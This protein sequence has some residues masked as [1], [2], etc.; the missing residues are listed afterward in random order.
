MEPVRILVL[1][2]DPRPPACPCCADLPALLRSLYPHPADIAES[3]ALPDGACDLVLVR[4]CAEDPAPITSLRERFPDLAILAL[5]CQSTH[6]AGLAAADD[7]LCCP[8][9]PFELQQ[10]LHRLCPPGWGRAGIEQQALRLRN[11]YRLEGLVGHS[12]PLLLAL[13]RLGPV[14]RSGATVLITGETGTGKELFARGVHYLS[15]RSGMPFLPVNCAA[16][17]DHLFENE[18]FGHSRGAYTD[19]STNENG[20]IQMAEGGTLFLDE[21]E[22]LSPAAQ[23][24]ILRF[25][26]DREYRPL[27]SPRSRRADI[28]IVGATNADLHQRV[29]TGQFRHDLFHRL[30]VLRLHVPPLSERLDDVPLLARHFAARFAA[31]FGR[32]VPSLSR[33]ALRKL[34]SYRWPG[35]VRELESVMQRAVVLAA[36][37]NLVRPG[38][39]DLDHQ[40]PAAAPAPTALRAAK[41][42]VVGQFERAYLTE[43]MAAHH[44]NVTRA[45]ESAGK[46]RRALQRLLRKHGIA[47]DAFRA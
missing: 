45:A 28:R 26:Q 29:S 16:L 20:L 40:P 33:P 35:N 10:R 34:M 8:F 12:E 7:F 42:A 30:N 22:T 5:A 38:D 4:C 9:H 31:Q 24:K 6:R 43:L 3:S 13:R 15:P 32:P 41:D 23:A 19:A 44:G 37:D 1:H 2:A 47:S 27:G 14:A 25:L 17:Q 21:V 36:D 39:I 11:Q 18:M 46:H